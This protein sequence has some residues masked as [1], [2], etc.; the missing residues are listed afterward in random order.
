LNQIQE[1][2]NS[3]RF[4]ETASIH[5]MSGKESHELIKRDIIEE[6]YPYLRS[7][8]IGI[9]CSYPIC[10]VLFF[11]KGHNFFHYNMLEYCEQE[12]LSNKDRVLCPDCL[13]KKIG[14]LS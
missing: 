9:E 6:N 4:N 12:K 13:V 8:L 2:L 5:A 10:C 14:D 1:L 3:E 11:L 7:F